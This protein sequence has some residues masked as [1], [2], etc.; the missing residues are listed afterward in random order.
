M[1]GCLGTSQECQ[2]AFCVIFSLGY[3]ARMNNLEQVQNIKEWLG[4][5][6]INI[7]GLP[8]AGKDTHGLELAKLLGAA[9]I[10]G[11]DILRS[12]AHQHVKEHIAKG[13]L[14]PTEAYLEMVLPY[15]SQAKFAGKPIVLSSVGRWHGE[16]PS[17]M[18]ACDESG[19]PIKAV[20]Y[21]DIPEGEAQ[22]RWEAAERG[23]EDD[24]EHHILQN[25]FNEFRGKT[26]PVIDYYRDEGLLIDIDATPPIESVS[27][28]ILGKLLLKASG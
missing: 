20:I 28:N 3:N 2:P 19:H 25:R 23:R 14:A 15:L 24:A 7:F 22:K 12:Q 18:K 4:A 8:F 6:S 27:A 5:G 26:L 16:E 17:V 13:H 11:G 10:S 1:L 21:L 9:F